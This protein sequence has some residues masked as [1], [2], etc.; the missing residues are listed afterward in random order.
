MSSAAFAFTAALARDVGLNALF[1]LKACLI[2]KTAQAVPKAC[3]AA[4]SPSFVAFPACSPYLQCQKY[5]HTSMSIMKAV[6]KTG[7]ENVIVKNLESKMNP[8]NLIA[9]ILPFNQI[10]GTKVL[11]LF[12]KDKNIKFLY[13]PQPDRSPYWNN[14]CLKRE[15]LPIKEI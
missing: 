2:L 11:N 5:D 1:G 8:S 15:H 13:G 12:H 7:T 6:M 4:F 14:T 3:P 10:T 9:M